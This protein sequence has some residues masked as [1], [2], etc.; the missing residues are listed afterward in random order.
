LTAAL[1]TAQL[2]ITTV[3]RSPSRLRIASLSAMFKRQP[4]VTTSGRGANSMRAI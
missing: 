2:L 4:R 3:S 1:V